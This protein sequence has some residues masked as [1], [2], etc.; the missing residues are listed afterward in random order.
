MDKLTGTLW[1]AYF[2]PQR[3]PQP[4][5]KQSARRFHVMLNVDFLVA[6]F[7]FFLCQVTKFRMRKMS[8][9]NEAK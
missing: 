6:D 4:S 9:N 1:T 5:Q 3:N 7:F 2:V 8:T